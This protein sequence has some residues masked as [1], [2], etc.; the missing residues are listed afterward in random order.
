[1]RT[2][3]RKKMIENEL[4][5]ATAKWPSIKSAH[6]GIS[7]IL[8]ELDEF[9]EAVREDQGAGNYKAKLEL[10]QVAAMA[11]RTLEDYYY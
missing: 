1:M 2:E 10:I 8:E 4:A 3:M 7:L 5:K 11:I 6:E 9:R